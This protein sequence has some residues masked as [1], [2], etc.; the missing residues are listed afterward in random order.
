MCKQVCLSNI[1]PVFAVLHNVSAGSVNEIPVDVCADMIVSE[2]SSTVDNRLYKNRYFDSGTDIKFATA[3]QSWDSPGQ[4]NCQ[5]LSCWF[6]VPRSFKVW[7]CC[8]RSSKH[9]SK[10]YARRD[11]SNG[12]W[13]MP[14]AGEHRNQFVW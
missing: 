3:P 10:V 5:Y 9:A 4:Y 2:A 11:L 1:L 13:A 7:L 14:V 8:R 6:D 12:F